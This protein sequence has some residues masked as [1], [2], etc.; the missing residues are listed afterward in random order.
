VGLIGSAQATARSPSQTRP[1]GIMVDAIAL[2]CAAGRLAETLRFDQFGAYDGTG[3]WVLGLNRIPRSDQLSMTETHEALHHE[4][5]AS[6]GWGLVTGWALLLSQRGFRRH[7]LNEVFLEL[8]E[9]SR[10]THEIFATTLSATQEGIDHGRAIL[11]DNLEY[12]AYLERGLALVDVPRTTPWQFRHAAMTSVLRVCMRPA[13]VLDVLERGF[14]DLRR[15]SFDMTRDSPDQRLAMYEQTGGQKSWS[16]VFAELL[17][18]YPDRGGDTAPGVHADAD[19]EA[20]DRLR[21]FEEEI[22]LPRCHC[23]VA[24]LLDRHEMPSIDT[25]RQ[26]VLAR[27][28]KAAV[29]EV[30]PELATWIQLNT[31]HQP[32]FEEALQYHR[33][34]IRLREPLSADLLEPAETLADPQLFRSFT[35][36]GHPYVCGVWLDCAVAAQQFDLADTDAPEL[37][38]A[39]GA[40]AH[41][42][43]G[44][45]TMR[46]GLLPPDVTP[47]QVQQRLNGVPLVVLTTHLTLARHADVLEML[48]TVEPVFVL[49]DLPVARHVGHW[50]SSGIPVR[51]SVNPVTTDHPAGAAPPGGPGA[52]PT[53]TALA[54]AIFALGRQHPFRFLCVGADTGIRVLAD[55]MRRRHPGAIEWDADIVGEYP[56]AATFALDFV[57]HAW[58]ELHQGAGLSGVTGAWSE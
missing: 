8:V 1:K 18:E 29:T 33:Q 26:S 11:A 10:A 54:V 31:Q 5:Q 48:Q 35:P 37:V 19:S 30:D 14:S 6:S 20:F 21:R 13:V 49:M 12:L 22:L 16:P 57:L 2:G 24:K 41:S 32:M 9:R 7:T 17:D 36:D 4:L 42:G 25:R 23:H 40:V 38:V 43:T 50:T 44:P 55:Q 53:D 58:H 15:G 52:G 45:R 47:Q 46:L 3:G 51:L 34:R 39:L 56:L 28:L 27:S